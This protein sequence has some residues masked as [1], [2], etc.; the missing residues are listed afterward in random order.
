MM[1]G[2]RNT[3]CGWLYH[4]KSVLLLAAFYRCGRRLLVKVAHS[5]TGFF[6]LVIGTYNRFFLPV[7]AT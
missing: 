5:R 1:R 7:I 4:Y 3:F 2:L 6:L